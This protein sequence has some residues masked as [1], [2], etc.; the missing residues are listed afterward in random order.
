MS[1]LYTMADALAAARDETGLNDFGKDYS[2]EPLEAFITLVQSDI[3]FT[4]AG[5]DNFKGMVQRH[6]VNHLRLQRDLAKHPEILN[7]DVSDP[8]MILGMPRTGTTKLQ[9]MISA[10][11]QMQKLALWRLL[12]P[13]PF[14]GDA[15]GVPG[16]RLLFARAV[17][18][19][20]IANADFTASHESAA[21]EADE[22]SYLLLLTFE[23][24]LLF[25][26][27]PSKAYLNWVRARPRM[28]S[29]AYEKQLLQYLQWQDGG[30]K[31][32]RWVLK[33]P[34]AVGCLKALHTIFPKATFVHSHRN[35]MDVMPSYCRL[36]EA[37]M[38]PL[39]N[40]LDRHRHGRDSLEFWAY[41]MA[42]YRQE[43]EQLRNSID[44][45]DV[46]Y[47]D[48]VK[49]PFP[50]IQLVYARAGVPFTA[51]AK[52]AMVAW[53]DRNQLHKNGKAVYALEDYGFTA[54]R[55]SNAF[56]GLIP[57]THMER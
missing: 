11:P 48:I 46:E 38:A 24:P 50:T 18:E 54:E 15:P 28:P 39:I 20:A 37:A 12:N 17:E 35:M 32:R 45:L 56:A 19:A 44:I 43:R 2:Y 55:I 34:G 4:R 8:I 29:H 23:Y 14:D 27:F 10:D 16:G 33:N 6:L 3:Q 41:E 49:D 52:A 57:A 31:G 22:D 25:A 9:R 53:S 47:L 5:F 13:A 40:N 7:E 30:R 26:L 1:S 21:E 36:M 51:E 42:L